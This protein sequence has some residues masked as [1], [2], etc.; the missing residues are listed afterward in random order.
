MK[1]ITRLET[2]KELVALKALLRSVHLPV[3]DIAQSS[4]Q[5][6][7]GIRDE[8]DLVASIG[9]ESYGQDALLR[10]LAVLPSYRNK[11]L[12]CALL[13]HAEDHAAQQRLSTLYLLTVNAQDFFSRQGYM[14]LAR[15]DAPASIA[16][17][18]QFAG[19]CP[20]S[21]VFLYKS[22]AH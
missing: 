1:T 19:L 17:S 9:L 16:A 15:E 21:A 3:S 18:A 14:R 10:S 4:S 11:G 5:T 20:A 8:L 6:L 12:A 22:I 13:R 7:F 2:T